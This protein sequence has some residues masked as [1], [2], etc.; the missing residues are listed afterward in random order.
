M[1]HPSTH[2]RL[3]RILIAPH[4]SI[5]L[6]NFTSIL[7]ISF[8]LYVSLDDI[9]ADGEGKFEVS[10]GGRQLS[11]DFT[12]PSCSCEDWC[13]H[14]YP[15]KHFF[16]I[17]ASCLAGIDRHCQQFTRLVREWWQAPKFWQRGSQPRSKNQ[18]SSRRK[19]LQRLQ[20]NCQHVRLV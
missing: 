18:P 15:C 16:A 3:V 7:L 19:I 20:M 9:A 12:V 5:L 4:G 1:L 14:G 13:L 11:V 8:C 17:F 6:I 2:L 10:S